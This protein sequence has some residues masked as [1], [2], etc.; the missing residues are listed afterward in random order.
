MTALSG[1]D[2]ALGDKFVPGGKND[3][4]IEVSG[5]SQTDSEV[6]RLVK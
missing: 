6:A 5:I 3:A 1:T 2:Y 4:D